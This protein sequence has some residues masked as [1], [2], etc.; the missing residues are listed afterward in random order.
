M[1]QP[2]VS[3]L[4]AGHPCS[5]SYFSAFLRWSDPSDRSYRLL[6][7]IGARKTGGVSDV[8]NRH[9]LLTNQ[10]PRACRGTNSVHALKVNQHDIT[11]FSG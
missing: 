4:C 9:E 7:E 11:D 3:K 8:G 10:S 1:F 6:G 5:C 2:V